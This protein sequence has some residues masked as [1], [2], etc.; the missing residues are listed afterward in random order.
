MSQ[1]PKQFGEEDASYQ[2][3]GEY[4]G[5]QALVNCFYDYM[6]K[7]PEALTILRMHPRDL[8]ESRDKLTRFLC[9][10][11][12]GPKL[13]SEKYG[14]IKIPMA[15]KHL[16]V[17][18]DER[19]AWLMCMQKAVDEQSFSEEFKLYFM[20]QIRVPAERVRQVAVQRK[21]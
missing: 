11:L 6:E 1:N 9:G 10:W 8:D 7:E 4:S 14:P 18:D 2:A 19:D 21:D 15:H 20:K 5:V 12:G 17:G 3:A 16:P 13:F